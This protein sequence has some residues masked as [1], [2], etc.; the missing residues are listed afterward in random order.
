MADQ[1]NQ[2]QTSALQKLK[3]V[4]NNATMQ[5]NFKNILADNAGAFMA[6]IIELFQSDKYL[7]ECDP[8]KVLLEAL[9]AATLKL[10][11]N[12]QM[13]FAYIV[14]YKNKGVPIPQFQLG[15]KGYIQL[16]MRTGQYRYINADIVYEGETVTHD[17]I[18]GMVEIVGEPTSEKPIGY[19]AYFELLNGF[20]KAVYWNKEKVAKH[21]QAK[22]KSWKSPTSAWHTD[23]D[24]MALKTVLRNIL[25]KYGVMSIEFVNAVSKDYDDSSDVEVAEKANKTDMTIDGE[26]DEEAR[27]M[28]SEAIVQ[29]VSESAPVV[30]P[31]F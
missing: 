25:S 13:G 20:K 31:G 3:A 17:R 24:A 6:S 1:Q 9:K 5:Q 14:P 4:L 16:A 18:T 8:N 15:Y 7:Q 30:D 2:L 12:K 21:A 10:S 29:Q 11:I 19:F 28:T 27:Q 23:F 22:S 26:F